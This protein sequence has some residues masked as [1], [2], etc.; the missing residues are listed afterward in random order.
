MRSQ[1]KALPY[2]TARPGGDNP[3]R[4]PLRKKEHE[5]LIASLDELI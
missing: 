2:G 5:L 3:P 1:E 4:E